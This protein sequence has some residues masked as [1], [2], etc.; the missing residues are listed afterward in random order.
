MKA[1]LFFFLMGAQ[2]VFARDYHFK[3]TV[4]ENLQDYVEHQLSIL[5][6]AS[7][8]PLLSLDGTAVHVLKVFESDKYLIW[9]GGTVEIPAVTVSA[10]GFYSINT[11]LFVI[12]RP[13]TETPFWKNGNGQPARDYRLV[14]NDLSDLP[15]QSF[16]FLRVM[17]IPAQLLSSDSTSMTAIKFE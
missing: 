8:G 1:V 3:S 6:V 16:H 12:H 9:E 7:R 15:V 11:I 13:G 14:S 4:V 2:V 5:Y 17:A 10:D